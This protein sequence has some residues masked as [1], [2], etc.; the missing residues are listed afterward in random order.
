ML[1]GRASNAPDT[2]FVAGFTTDMKSMCYVEFVDLVF[3]E[4][5]LFQIDRVR[6]SRTS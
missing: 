4:T 1:A 3:A 6:P 2:S 5:A